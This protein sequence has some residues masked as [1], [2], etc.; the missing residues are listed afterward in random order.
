MESESISGAGSRTLA[1]ASRS[2]ATVF[3]GAAGN[4]RLDSMRGRAAR[5]AVSLAR[6]ARLSAA[7]TI[8]LLLD[9][10][11]K[12]A[13]EYD[14]RGTASVRRLRGYV[15][16]GKSEGDSKAGERVVAGR[17]SRGGIEAASVAACSSGSTEALSISSSL[18]CL[19]R[20]ARTFSFSS[21]RHAGREASAVRTEK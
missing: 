9:A 12:L 7:W 19:A 11:C 5:L 1:V 8:G 21:M 3:F 13:E 15:S 18:V 17:P 20:L 2:T 16:S 14:A 6:R 10:L 4:G